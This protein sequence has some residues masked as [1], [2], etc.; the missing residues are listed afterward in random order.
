MP[1]NLRTGVMPSLGRVL[2]KWT[3][4][5][6]KPGDHTKKWWLM[7]GFLALAAVIYAVIRQNFLF[8]L[9]IIMG[10]IIFVSE[11]R[12]EPQRLVCQI[13]S[14]GLYLG[15][16]FWR[17]NELS[18]FWI[19]YRPPEINR[20]Y[21]VPKNLAEPRLTIPLGNNNPLHVR[22]ALL[23]YI[24]E[25]LEREDEPTSEALSRLLGLE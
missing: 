6:P 2:L 16:K 20:L 14:T 17:W 24:P 12:R 13:T 5:E 4:K 8:A 10:S 23:K 3:F 1:I 11:T 25:D 9:I 15:K 22:E 7:A 21:V 19:A 18:N